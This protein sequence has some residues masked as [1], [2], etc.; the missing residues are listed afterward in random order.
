MK[1]TSSCAFIMRCGNST[2]RSSNFARGVYFQEQYPPKR[3]NWKPPPNPQNHTPPEAIMLA[4]VFVMAA[5]T[6]P[7]TTI[8]TLAPL[9][10]IPLTLTPL[11]PT[12]LPGYHAGGGSGSTCLLRRRCRRRARSRRLPT[13]GS[14]VQTLCGSTAAACTRR[15]SASSTPGTQ[16]HRTPGARPCRC[17]GTLEPEVPLA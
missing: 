3:L 5:T 9:R 8:G 14:S 17:A 12:P 16:S 11:P 7:P 13:F 10:R 6:S 2:P 1:A 15:S 4:D